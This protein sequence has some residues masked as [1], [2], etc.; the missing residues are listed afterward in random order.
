MA[1]LSRFIAP[2]SFGVDLSIMVIIMLVLGG[3]GNL[4]GSI[5]GAAIMIIAVELLR[6]IAEVRIAIIGLVMILVPIYRPHGLFVGITG[7]IK[8]W[9]CAAQRPKKLE[10]DSP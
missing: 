3:M 7:D 9:V 1:T 10:S 5:I 2:N 4:K 8:R 6:P